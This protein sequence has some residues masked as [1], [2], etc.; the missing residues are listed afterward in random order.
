MPKVQIVY[1]AN[2][3]RDFNHSQTIKNAITFNIQFNS[4]E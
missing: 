3:I 1:Y 2:I 4:L